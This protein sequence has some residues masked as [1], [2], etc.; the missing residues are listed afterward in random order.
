ML[1][2]DYQIGYLR[3]NVKVREARK[4][5][6][7][8]ESVAY[9]LSQS[10]RKIPHAAATAQFD[11]TALVEYAKKTGSASDEGSDP[12]SEQAVLRRAIR[13]RFSAFFIKTIAHCLHHVPEMN[14]F[15]DYA[16]WRTGGTLYIADDIN[17]SF[18]VD[19][20][21]GVI[22]PIIRNPHLKDL[23]TV[24]TEMRGL[25]RKARRTDPEELYRAAARSYV[26]SGLRQLDITAF[27]V[28]WVWLRSIL[29]R[30]TP[31]PSTLDIPEEDKLQVRD[32]LGSTC[33]VAN[34]GMMI[35]GH[36]T[37]T[38]IIP[39]EVTM[40]GIGNLRQAPLVIDDKIV[41][42][43]VI[44]IAGTIDHRAFDG[45]EGFPFY[46]KMKHYVDH[47]ELIYEWKPGDEI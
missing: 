18:T 32:I 12:K 41:P 3:R 30:H 23:E 4:L 10:A 14:A 2:Q 42:R 25:T 9:V 28:L 47:P 17:L 16:P 20:K 35:E 37:V 8:R 36:Q 46:D 43:Y 13:K 38:V 31:D 26:L 24:A 34:I 5:S 27:P 11:V 6:F 21:F 44:T 39:P 15:L 33:T 7:L 22:K 45:G 1:F 40:F 29:S 19:T